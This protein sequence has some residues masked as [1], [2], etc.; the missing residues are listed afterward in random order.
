MIL[1]NASEYSTVG[2]QLSG[3]VG[4]G[5]CPDNWITE[6]IVHQCT[7]AYVYILKVDKSVILNVL[8]MFAVHVITDFCLFLCFVSLLHCFHEK[9]VIN[10]NYTV[11]Y[12]YVQYTCSG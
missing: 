5:R 11:L 3:Q 4:T 10:I 1:D 8:V 9:K 6:V 2:C 7:H 12:M